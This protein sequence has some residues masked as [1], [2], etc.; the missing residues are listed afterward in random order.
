[1]SFVTG[2]ESDSQAASDVTTD[3]ML[4]VTSSTEKLTDG[5]IHHEHLQQAL[6][7][8]PELNLEKHDGQGLGKSLSEV[9]VN[10]A[11][12]FVRGNLTDQPLGQDFLETCGGATVTEYLE[13][14]QSNVEEDL[15]HTHDTES[16]VSSVCPTSTEPSLEALLFS[17]SEDSPEEIIP[18]AEMQM[19][20][21]VHATR[22]EH[23]EDR[24]TS[25]ESPEKEQ[26]LRMCPEPFLTN[27]TG[28]V[29]RES[30]LKISPSTDDQLIDAKLHQS[31][32]L[33]RPQYEVPE[34]VLADNEYGKACLMYTMKSEM[35]TMKI[36]D[37]M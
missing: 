24:E 7:A 33:E 14:I 18:N 3:L 16:K 13:G 8:L 27:E 5:E 34:A 1:M 17:L 30:D 20:Q 37:E 29:T 32:E 15:S 2:E 19:D 4:T 35:K 22:V 28:P 9:T 11:A 12:S 10:E 31:C 6:V 36:S 21:R 23:Q 25:L 26:P